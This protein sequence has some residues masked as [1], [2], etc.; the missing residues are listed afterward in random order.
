MFNEQIQHEQEDVLEEICSLHMEQGDE[1]V[2]MQASAGEFVQEDEDDKEE[3]ED[4]RQDEDDG[5]CDNVGIG[6]LTEKWGFTNVK[7]QNFCIAHTLQLVMK[8]LVKQSIIVSEEVAQMKKIVQHIRKIQINQ[9][10]VKELSGKILINHAA[11]RWNLVAL[12]IGTLLDV[13]ICLQKRN[14]E[15]LQVRNFITVIIF[16]SFLQPQVF[17]AIQVVLTE[18]GNADDP[19]VPL[20]PSDEKY[21]LWQF[22]YLLLWP[23]LAATNALQRDGITTHR[24]IPEI[25][26][27]YQSKGIIRNILYKVCN[28]TKLLYDYFLPTVLCFVPTQG[29]EDWDEIKAKCIELFVKRMNPVCNQQLWITSTVLTYADGATF[30][31]EDY[32]A[33]GEFSLKEFFIFFT[34][35]NYKKN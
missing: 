22:I 26:K 13:R 29:R 5:H 33:K 10:I 3:E 20:P 21:K 17:T 35:K 27:L 2:R 24:V 6:R 19:K 23:F 34:V 28:Y 12:M 32:D 14:L 15:K 4:G 7:G 31:F 30:F 11:T 18:N 1:G 16:L 9:A 8:D 25:A